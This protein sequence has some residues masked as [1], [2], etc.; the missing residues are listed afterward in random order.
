MSGE[1]RN[2]GFGRDCPDSEAWE[3]I[4]TVKTIDMK[5]QTYQ[6]P[7]TG[8]LPLLPSGAVLTVSSEINP[9][10]WD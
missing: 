9:A 2:M 3:E 4:Q 6:P 1:K 8:V 5:K 7:Q 10:P